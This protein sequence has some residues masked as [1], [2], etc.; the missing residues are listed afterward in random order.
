MNS[1]QL[2][3]RVCFTICIICIAV[4]AALSLSMIWTTYESEFLW[5]SWATM[6]VLFFASAATLVVSRVV[7]GKAGVPSQ[8]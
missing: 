5:K 2:L 8:S 1:W 6:G 7:G 4:G 3:N